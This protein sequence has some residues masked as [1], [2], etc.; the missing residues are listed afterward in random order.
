VTVLNHHTGDTF[1]RAWDAAAVG[2]L[3][4]LDAPQGLHQ[5]VNF[6]AF[7][8]GALECE[9]GFST[10]A[11]ALGA[12][13][14]ISGRSFEEQDSYVLFMTLR[15][16][17]GLLAGRHEVTLRVPIQERASA[18]TR[19]ELALRRQR[20][21]FAEREA[22][23][24]RD[25]DH[26]RSEAR[27]TSISLIGCVVLLALGIATIVLAQY[28]P[29][30]AGGGT[31][32]TDHEVS[33]LIRDLVHHPE[34]YGSALEVAVAVFGVLLL[35]IGQRLL[36]TLLFICGFVSAGTLCLLLT[37]LIFELAGFFS[38]P[39]LGIAAACGGVLGGVV[40]HTGRST[41]FFLMGALSGAVIGWYAYVLA[42]GTLT[43]HSS[44]PAVWHWVTVGVPGLCG[45]CILA[46]NHGP[47]ARAISSSVVGACAVVVAL[48][49][50]LLSHHDRRFSSWLVLPRD[51]ILH[52]ILVDP[53]L[54]ESIYVLGPVLA[55]VLLS[56]LGACFQCRFHGADPE[57]PASTRE[58]P[59]GLLSEPLLSTVD[60]G[61]VGDVVV[62]EAVPVQSLDG[63]IQVQAA[64]QIQAS[65]PPSD[66]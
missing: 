38:C 7:V 36:R 33:C 54:S 26:V 1:R 2:Q 22:A 14:E 8:R 35:T 21:N 59:I 55:A 15:N 43:G 31:N 46:C 17:D 10:A 16:G 9:A 37:E 51:N 29:H 3:L 58:V 42:V 34:L 40:A 61:F 64:G 28:A 56:V 30:D 53:S 60:S 41:S 5:L 47:K 49:L 39:V 24:R 11:G 25:L 13:T 65:A 52:P 20:A 23:M 45:G 57:R 63:S 32:Q 48:D 18:E 4:P 62:A 6:H 27:R 50:L 12:G 44:E 66:A 19:H